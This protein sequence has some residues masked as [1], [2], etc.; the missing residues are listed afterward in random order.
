MERVVDLGGE[1]VYAV[2]RQHGRVAGGSALLTASGVLVYEWRDR[3]ILR[4]FACAD[5]DTARAAAERL[6]EERGS[7]MSQEKVEPVRSIYAAW[8]R[9]EFG[10]ADWAR[11]EIEYGYADGPDPGP[12]R[13]WKRWQRVPRLA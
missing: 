13:A 3:A 1:I 12:G 9:G 2:Y 8:E 5:S 11:P 4:V 6:A 10:S 7:V